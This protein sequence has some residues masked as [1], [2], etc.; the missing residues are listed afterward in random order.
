MEG[1]PYKFSEEASGSSF[2]CF[3]I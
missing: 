3:W 2:K 1:A